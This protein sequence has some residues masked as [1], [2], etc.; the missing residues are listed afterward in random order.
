M[1]ILP[2]ISNFDDL[3]PLEAEPDVDLVRVRRGEFIPGDCD[4][5]L[6]VGSKA[7][8]SDLA[9]LREAGFDVDIA[10]HVRRGGYVL[11]LCGG[12]QMLGRTISDPDG[13]EGAPGFVEGLGLLDVETVLTGEK[14]LEAVI[15]Q[16]FDSVFLS[17]YEMHVGRT[18]GADCSRP[19]SNIAGRP[20]GAVSPNGRILGTYLHGLFSDDAQRSAWLERLGGNASVLDYEEDIDKVLDRL[21]GHM[22]QHL[23]LTALLRLAR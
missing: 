18:D 6:L 17:G 22:E 21:A 16:S 3:D 14:R 12:Y 20:E 9:S 13:I 19:F 8:I 1:P 15:G 23:D 11:G 4:L 5:V 2:H 10:A 7:T